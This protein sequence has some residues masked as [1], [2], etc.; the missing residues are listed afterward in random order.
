M[1]KKNEPF[2]PFYE[3]VQIKELINKNN[4]DNNN[5]FNYTKEKDRKDKDKNKLDLKEDVIND[6]SI[7]K[8]NVKANKIYITPLMEKN[9]IMRHPF[10]LMISG[11]SG[12][13]KTLLCVNLLRRFMKNYFDVLFLFSSSCNKDNTQEL[14]NIPKQNTQS[15]LDD[16]AIPHLEHILSVQEKEIEKVGIDKADKILIIFDDIVA[17]PKFL[18]SKIYKKILTMGRHYNISSISLI[19][20]YYSIPRVLR[21]QMSDVCVFVSTCSE[22]DAI[23]EEYCPPG[24]TPKDMRLLLNEATSEPFSFLYINVREPVETR[25]RKNLDTYLTF[26]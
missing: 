4:N 18:N 10:R 14:L 23:S 1:T 22:L 21:L 5:N 7:K 3:D 6:L 25:F 17:S 2:I 11:P 15:D 12:S 26:Q 19:Q 16:E 20:R 24:K 8:Y 13:G 9:Y